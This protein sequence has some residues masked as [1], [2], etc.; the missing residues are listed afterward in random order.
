VVRALIPILFVFVSALALG[1]TE[2]QP[3]PALTINDVVAMLE[4]KLPEQVI[5]QR[6][7]S[8][9]RAF[10]LTTEE[11]VRLKNASA[12]EK[13][14]VLM[15]DPGTRNTSVPSPTGAPAPASSTPTAGMIPDEVGAYVVKNATAVPLKVEVV[16]FKT[17]GM[18]KSMGT[19]GISKAKFLGILA[20]IESPTRVALPSV[21]VLRCADG[22]DPGEYQL[23]ALEVKKDRREFIGGKG[24]LTG[25]SMGVAGI[26]IPLKF[27]RVERNVYRAA[28]NDLKTGEFGILPPGTITATPGLTSGKMF[29]V[30]VR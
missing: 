17:A 29:T 19:I 23:V 21:L 6:I 8:N 18:L 5:L 28:L 10:N 7:K 3:T 12:T 16:N 27:E 14:M 25:V 20:G 30:G 15:M 1:Q 22:A 2:S 4:A 26:A 9:G 24:G 11:L 13:A